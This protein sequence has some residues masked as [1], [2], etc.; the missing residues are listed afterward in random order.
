MTFKRSVVRVEIEM[1]KLEG[2]Y[3]IGAER[4]EL[5]AETGNSFAFLQAV[6]I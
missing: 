3:T 1:G 2:R 6:R 4:N 5:T